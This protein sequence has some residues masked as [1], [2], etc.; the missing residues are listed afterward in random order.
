M[1]FL[2]SDLKRWKMMGKYLK[3]SFKSGKKT[4]QITDMKTSSSIQLTKINEIINDFGKFVADFPL[5]KRP[6]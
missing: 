5:K 1:F 3:E 6:R 4:Y 2:Q